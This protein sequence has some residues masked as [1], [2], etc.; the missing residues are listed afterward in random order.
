MTT[1]ANLLARKQ[2]LIEPLQENPGLHEREEI[3]RQLAEIDEALNLLVEAGPGTSKRMSNKRLGS[4]PTSL[5]H[6]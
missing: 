6:S 4:P 3:E 5:S 2:E 1:L